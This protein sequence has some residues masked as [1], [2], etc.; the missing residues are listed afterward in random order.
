MKLPD[1]RRHRNEHGYEEALDLAL[2]I[3]AE[4][5]ELI[6]ALVNQHRPATSTVTIEGNAM[7][8]VGTT[9][10]ATDNFFKA[11]GSADTA[12]AGTTV[13]FHSDNPAVDTVDP[14]SGLVTRVSAGK[15]SIGATAT[16]PD[17]T[18]QEAA[19][20]ADDVTEPNPASST[21]TLA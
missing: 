11:D 5:Q 3:I 21:V 4:L 7:P 1:L 2:A 19:A 16:F 17:G 6:I 14:T 12:P 15:A 9:A 20:A 10:Q 13:I 8:T 18:T